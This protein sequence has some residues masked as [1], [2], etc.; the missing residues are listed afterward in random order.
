MQGGLGDFDPSSAEQLAALVHKELVFEIGGVLVRV[1]RHELR[2]TAELDKMILQHA[3]ESVSS[4]S[5][6]LPEIGDWLTELSELRLNV[7]LLGWNS[8]P[9]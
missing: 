4:L 2:K 5:R 3:L 6:G 9:A 8:K 1:P 7:S